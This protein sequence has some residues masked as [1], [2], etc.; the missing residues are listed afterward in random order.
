MSSPRPSPMSADAASALESN[1]DVGA[2]AY[3]TADEDEGFDA[4]APNGTLAAAALADDAAGPPSPE[5]ENDR[6]STDDGD[7]DDDGDARPSLPQQQQQKERG[8]VGEG[9]RRRKPVRRRTRPMR[10]RDR[11]L[12]IRRDSIFLR[13]VV[14]SVRELEYRTIIRRDNIV[15]DGRR[16]WPVL[17]NERCGSVRGKRDRERGIYIDGRREGN[18]ENAERAGRVFEVALGLF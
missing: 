12:S 3:V 18:T 9:R 11:L 16:R 10:V 6:I 1:D 5:G 4:R 13:S 8:G 7:D 15:G 14:R 17:C 2:T